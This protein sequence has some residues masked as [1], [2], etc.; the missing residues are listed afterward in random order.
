MFKF[1]QLFQM[2]YAMAFAYNWKFEQSMQ[3]RNDNDQLISIRGPLHCR[4][5]PEQMLKYGEWLHQMNATLGAHVFRPSLAKEVAFRPLS[6]ALIRGHA[7]I[8][9]QSMNLLGTAEC[10]EA[11]TST[12]AE[13]HER[14]LCPWYWNL[15]YD[16][17]RIPSLLPEAVCKCKSQRIADAV[18]ECH[19]MK[20]HVRVLKFVKS[21]DEFVL[22]EA[23]IG[24]ACIAVR[25]A[26]ESGFA[27]PIDQ[28]KAIPDPNS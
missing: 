11:A 18:Y 14:S 8:G 28:D 1:N 6:E 13:L 16:P 7:T 15:N 20:Y 24:M 22:G 10:V 9:E 21:C 27:A 3:K 19:A 26:R 23:A 4:P 12:H 5:T 25:T 17:N 2:F